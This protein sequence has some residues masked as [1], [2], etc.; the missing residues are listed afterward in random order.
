MPSYQIQPFDLVDIASN[1]GGCVRFKVDGFWSDSVLQIYISYDH[2]FG[3]GEQEWKIE[4]SRSSGGRD[5]K[6]TDD[7]K[8]NENMIEAMQY[9]V[10]LMKELRA[11]ADT[12]T[13][14]VESYR[15]GIR[16]EQSIKDKKNQEDYLNDEPLTEKFL[17]DMRQ[18]A[19]ETGECHAKICKRGSSKPDFNLVAIYYEITNRVS[20]YRYTSD[21]H[22]KRRVYPK[23][24]KLDT[25]SLRWSAIMDVKN[26]HQIPN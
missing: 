15:A 25:Y 4:L 26:E 13:K 10:L 5:P 2:F 1:G 17:D 21:F 6:M 24:V 19:R 20:F 16:L 22:H 3:F 7:I 12:M 8:A 18:I 23:D 9:A 14:I 11:Q